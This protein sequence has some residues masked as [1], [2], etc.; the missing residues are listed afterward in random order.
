MTEEKQKKDNTTKTPEFRSDSS[1]NILNFANLAI[2]LILIGLVFFLIK[3]RIILG[4]FLAAT[5]LAVLLTPA[6]QFLEKKRIPKILAILM[7]YLVIFGIFA[8]AI[9]LIVPVV[10]RQA[11]DVIDAYPEY[12]SKAIALYEDFRERLAALGIGQEPGDLFDYSSLKQHEALS[13]AAQRAISQG[14]QI[15]LA[16]AS[17]IT[18]MISIPVIAFYLLKD[19]PVIRKTL[20]N[21]IPESWHGSTGELLGKLSDSVYNYLKGQVLLCLVMFLIT[22]PILEI[23]GVPYALLLAV[24]AG[25]AEFIPIIGPTIA[26]IP[27]VLIAIFFDFGPESRGLITGLSDIWRGLT[28]MFTYFAI[29]LSESNLLVPRIMGHTMDIHPLGVIFAL[30]CGAVIAGIWGMLL[31]LPVAAAVKVIYQYYYPSFVKRID[32]LLSFEE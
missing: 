2:A 27:A 24:L 5:V 16:S 21:L 22:W 20:I 26:L 31:S 12:R 19:G 8:T 6:V 29:Q 30:L 13:S 32:K 15:I 4:I 28:V 14:W 10:V 17:V 3:I 25:L 23:L 11:A 7:V 9:T 18:T 1:K